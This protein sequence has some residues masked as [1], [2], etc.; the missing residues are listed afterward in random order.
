MKRI[1]FTHGKNPKPTPAAHRQQLLR[2]L[3]HGVAKVNPVVAA[4]IEADDCFT[5]VSWSRLFYAEHRAIADLL[6]WIDRLLAEADP[7]A[8][9]KTARPLK[10]RLARTLYTLGDHLPWLI[11]LIPDPRVRRSIQ[12]TDHYFNNHD[13]TAC[14]IRELQKVPL[15]A[16]AARGERTLLI[17]H[18]MGSIIAYDALWELQHL[19]GLNSCVDWLLTLGSPLGMHYVQ[20]RLAGR[21]TGSTP[22][23]PCNFN[24]WINISS[25]GDLVALDPILA[26]D[27]REMI[28]NHCIDS[29]RD[30][31][32]DVLNHYRD[33]KGLNVHKSYGYLVNPH[34]AQVIVEWWQQA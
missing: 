13:N 22:R 21:A 18:S 2:C 6:P 27:F 16:A 3:L 15:R 31:R 20:H 34:V 25:R 7:P 24:Q 33:G 26:N 28:D 11:P 4:E 14:R 12:E 8:D 23:Y 19:E 5:L 30:M 1:I 10:Y 32:N 17:G 29:I 9:L